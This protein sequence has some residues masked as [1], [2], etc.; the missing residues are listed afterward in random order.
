MVADRA[1]DEQDVARPRPI[2]GDVDAGRHDTDAGRGD[3]HAVALTLLHDLGVPRDD[4]E[5]A[6]ATPAIDK[7][8]LLRSASGKP[9]SITN[10]AATCSGI[11][12]II[13]T[14]LIV[15]WTDKQPMS[16]PGKNSGDTT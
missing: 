5:P 3:E 9:S 13:A 1:A 11:A 10:A 4:R 7:T 15:P 8:I 16:P 2:T 6:F 14:S 12:P